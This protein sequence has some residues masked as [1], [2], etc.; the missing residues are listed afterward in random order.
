MSKTVQIQDR[1]R[2]GNASVLSRCAALGPFLACLLAGSVHAGAW[3][4][5][6]A[7]CLDPYEN[8]AQAVFDDLTPVE[9][10]K[11]HVNVSLHGG[12]FALEDGAVLTSDPTPLMSGER[13]CAVYG[14]AQS[15]DAQVWITK[16]LAEKSYELE[17]RTEDGSFIALTNLWIEP[18][19][20]VSVEF[21]QGGAYVVYQIVETD[22]ES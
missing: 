4:E 17:G 14:R 15:D 2:V 6:E 21:E 7:R 9:V 19:L 12:H 18:K 10:L 11:P 16:K 13:L 3:E 1:Y 22:L 20:N 5:F 8:L